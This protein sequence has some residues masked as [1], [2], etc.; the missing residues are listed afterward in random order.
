MPAC[1]ADLQAAHRLL[2]YM[3]FVDCTRPPPPL[4]TPHFPPPN[5]GLGQMKA[6]GKPELFFRH[7]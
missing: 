2:Y 4:S 6:H 7:A 3:L 5:I 1:T